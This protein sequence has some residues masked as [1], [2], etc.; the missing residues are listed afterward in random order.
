[1]RILFIGVQ[2][3]PDEAA[4]LA[5]ECASGVEPNFKS[6]DPLG[7][8]RHTASGGVTRQ[9]HY[10]GDT[11]TAEYDGANTI[12]RRYVHGPG[13]D[14]PLVWYEGT[15][16]AVRKWLIADERGSV[17]ALANDAALATQINVYDEYGVSGPANQGRFQYTGQ[18]YLPEVL[19]HEVYHVGEN[20]AVGRPDT[21][22][23]TPWGYALGFVQG[24]I[25]EGNPNEARAYSVQRAIVAD[26]QAKGFAGC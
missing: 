1:M 26:L 10:D 13:A 24:G 8:L 17:I 19:V 16:T 6:Y 3:T 11:L 21:T 9:F 22:S 23:M 5:G 14:E 7:R 2:L 4:R 25:G 12:L 20:L 15:G 18:A